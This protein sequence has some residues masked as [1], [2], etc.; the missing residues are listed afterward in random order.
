MLQFQGSKR[1]RHDSVIKK[2]DAT[3]IPLYILWSA[4]VYLQDNY[5]ALPSVSVFKIILK[6]LR[7]VHTYIK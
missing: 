6:A 5:E 7:T 2:K 3:R 1:V 4:S